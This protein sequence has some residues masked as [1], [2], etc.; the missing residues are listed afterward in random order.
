MA[1]E[2]VGR[3]TALIRSAVVLCSMF[4][5]VRWAEAVDLL[6]TVTKPAVVR[7]LRVAGVQ[8]ADAGSYL[9]VESLHVPWTGDCAGLNVLALVLM[10][11]LWGARRMALSKLFL[12][13]LGAA[14]LAFGA[15]LARILTLVAYRWLAE[16]AVETPTMHYFVGFLWVLP[17]VPWLLPEARA[18]SF[19]Q[20]LQVAVA[21][22]LL[23]PLA[24]APGGT[25]AVAASL[26]LLAQASW[27]PRVPRAQS[28]LWVLAALPIALARMESLWLPWVLACPAFCPWRVD[29]N[30]VRQLGLL[31]G[32]TPPLGM[33]A[34]GAILGWM[35]LVWTVLAALSRSRSNATETPGDV[36]CG[37]WWRRAMVAAWML[38][39]F[40]AV[41]SGRNTPPCSPPP[42]VMARKMDHRVHE[43]RWSGLPANLSVLWF[44]A[45]GDGRHHTLPVCMRYRGVSLVATDMPG[46]MTDG[47]HWYREFFIHDRE[48]VADYRGY[49]RKTFMPGSEIGV[50]VIVVGPVDGTDGPGDFADACRK[51]EQ[52]LGGASCAATQ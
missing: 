25:L 4:G 41:L 49:L 22:A 16:P 29:R 32:A 14:L 5:L 23:S 10:V 2:A 18:G 45:Q 33:T 31:L 13:L 7:L 34:A 15:N 24:N 44:G 52:R 47:T 28:E 3:M 36:P 43:L 42:G 11:S 19:L 51:V 1:A 9:Q 26:A 37:R 8:A 35:A 30:S 38:F 40:I 21:L 17:V 6:S 27:Q 39:P 48:L 50:H 46:V 12:R 20:I